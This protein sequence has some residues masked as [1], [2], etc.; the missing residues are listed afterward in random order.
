MQVMPQRDRRGPCSGATRRR[1]LFHSLSFRITAGASRART[2]VASKGQ[3]GVL[4][5]AEPRP[6]VL[7]VGVWFA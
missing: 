7:M 1:H 4:G 3:V 2:M 5:H 6:G